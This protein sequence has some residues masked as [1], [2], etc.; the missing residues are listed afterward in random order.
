MDAPALE[1]R[2]LPSRSRIARDEWNR[3]AGTDYPFLRHEFLL[4]LEETGCT[5]ADSGW[6]PCHVTLYRDERLV[7]LMPLYLKSHS[8]GEY[9]FDW[10]WADAYHRNGRHYYPK[11]LTAIPFLTSTASFCSSCL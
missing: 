3:L 5:D 11:L 8:Y 6:Q 9:V 10:S 4:A 2:F 7:G 1:A